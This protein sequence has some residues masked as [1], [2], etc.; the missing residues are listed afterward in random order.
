MPDVTDK[1]VVLFKLVGET[2][3]WHVPLQE[4]ACSCIHWCNEHSDWR[5]RPSTIWP[6]IFC[7]GWQVH[8]KWSQVQGGFF[9][10]RRWTNQ[11]CLNESLMCLHRHDCMLPLCMASSRMHTCSQGTCLVGRTP[12]WRLC[13]G[14][15]L[16]SIDEIINM[17]NS[18]EISTLPLFLPRRTLLAY[19]DKNGKLPSTWFLQLD[20]TCK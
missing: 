6:A 13:T 16:L 5:C 9:T 18:S 3:T 4:C 10:V 2:R 1:F 19:I 17:T 7:P 15:I 14:Y 8:D 11:S 12:W 20:N